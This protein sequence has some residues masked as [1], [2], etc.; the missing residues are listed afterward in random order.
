[1]KFVYR[2]PNTDYNYFTND[3]GSIIYRRTQGV[4]DGHGGHGFEH[5]AEME[6]IAARIADQKIAEAIPKVQRAAYISAYNDLV[7]ALEFDVT[8]AV[9]IGL[10]NCGEIFYDSKTQKI[11]AEA[12]MR[13]LKKQMDKP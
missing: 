12:V 1:M 2:N 3:D 6:Q 9:S 8:S 10:E 7:N 11:L 13:E 4:R 5:R